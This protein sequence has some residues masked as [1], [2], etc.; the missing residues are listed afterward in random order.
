MSILNE[1]QDE[2]EE[3]VLDQENTCPG[4]DTTRPHLPGEE[5]I[6]SGWHFLKCDASLS[7]D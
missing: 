7:T 5:T 3:K 4:K 6:E 1:E 2:D